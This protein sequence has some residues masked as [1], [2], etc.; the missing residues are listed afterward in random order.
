MSALGDYL[1]IV[2]QKAG[3]SQRDVYEKTGIT[4]SRLSRIERSEVTCPL[5]ELRKL[6]DLYQ[7]SLV[8]MLILGGYLTND[9]LAKYQE[10]FKGASKLDVNE[11]ECIQ[12]FINLLT[13]R[14]EQA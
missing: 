4:D 5:A 3:Y 7:V 2:R 10:V 8:D 14:M 11:K 1:K 6:A 9:D 12:Q 13:K